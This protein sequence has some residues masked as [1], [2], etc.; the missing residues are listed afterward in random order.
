ME[1][2]PGAVHRA[3]M[4]AVDTG[5][6]R[7]VA[8]RRARRYIA[9]VLPD[10]ALRITV[11]RCGSEAGA[12]RFAAQLADWTATQRARFAA[13]ALPPGWNE[14]AAT[15]LR[16][17]RLELVPRVGELAHVHGLRVARVSVRRQRSRWGSCS[18]QGVISLN[19]RLV[20]APSFV[21]DYVILHELMHLR[22][23]NH[24]ARFWAL[25]DAACPDRAEAEAWL[26]RHA[27][28]LQ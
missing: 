27:A 25:V 18:R 19:A 4:K 23:M 10:G 13:R 11:P 26:K 3:E 9:R 21:R 17:A 16:R 15:L 2:F 5:E 12:L 20:F 8:N 1:L 24:S 14:P 6:V 28:Y 7:L 22:E